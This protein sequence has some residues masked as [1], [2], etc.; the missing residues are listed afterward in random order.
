MIDSHLQ[1]AIQC[2]EAGI[3]KLIECV[4]DAP[5]G[6]IS[7]RDLNHVDAARQFAHSAIEHVKK[8]DSTPLQAVPDQPA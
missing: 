2:F 4:D 5:A 7:L 8:A 6:A 3:D 1:Q